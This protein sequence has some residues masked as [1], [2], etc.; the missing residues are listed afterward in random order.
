MANTLL[1]VNTTILL[2]SSVVA[3]QKFPPAPTPRSKFVVLQYLY[4]NILVY[5][6]IN[7]FS[8][9]HKI[10]HFKQML[11]LLTLKIYFNMLSKCESTTNQY[12][13]MYGTGSGSTT[14]LVSAISI[15]I[16]TLFSLML[17]V[18]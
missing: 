5:S 16:C 15:F 4:D 18:C 7:F 8:E 2:V 14:L 11:F 9:Q 17:L 6:T 10:V 3:I 13:V 12:Y 1:V